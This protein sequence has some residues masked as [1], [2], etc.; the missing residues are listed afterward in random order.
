MMILVKSLES[1]RSRSLLTSNLVRAVDNLK[2][3]KDTPMVISGSSVARESLSHLYKRA[4]GEK[5]PSA[6]PS[7]SLMRKG[8]IYTD[9]NCTEQ[10]KKA[11]GTMRGNVKVGPSGVM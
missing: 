6:K 4:L 5:A 3:K 7:S 8:S 1:R 9:H 10:T 11:V 2:E